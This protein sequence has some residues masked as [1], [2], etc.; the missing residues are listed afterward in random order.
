MKK[1][2]FIKKNV[3]NEYILNIDEEIFELSEFLVQIKSMELTINEQ[4]ALTLRN[5]TFQITKKEK[6]Y[7][8][9]LYPILIDFFE[10]IKLKINEQRKFDLYS[11]YQFYAI[12]KE[13]L[14]EN[15][16]LILK[17]KKIEEQSLR[18]HSG[19]TIFVQFKGTYSPKHNVFE[20]HV[21]SQA[22]LKQLSLN[23]SEFFNKESL[24]ENVINSNRRKEFEDALF[25]FCNSFS[26]QKYKFYCGKTGIGKTVTLLNYRFK[27]KNVFYINLRIIFKYCKTTIKLYEIIKN[28][29]A[30][31]FSNSDEYNNFV[32]DTD[33]FKD[34][35]LILFNASAFIYERLRLIIIKLVNYY[36]DY[37]IPLLIILDQYKPK[38]DYYSQLF[39]TLKSESNN[40]L[41][42]KFLICSSINE[43]EI[44]DNIYNSIY[45]LNNEENKYSLIDKLMD[46]CS[47][48]NLSEN[49]KKS[50]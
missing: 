15:F 19:S 7:E 44:K 11:S 37:P 45:I 10:P 30:F 27:N 24:E 47:F 25:K 43:E 26:K 48:D 33:I 38:Y 20:R 17:D 13:F 42:L 1:D 28:E 29:L 14:Q 4:K 46:D 8:I 40:H 36:K 21:F 9:L 5:K 35:N 2:V 22:T 34:D 6:Y 41:Y 31:V 16:E 18:D 3:Q 32:N 12:K 49:K 39:E 50:F 23:Y